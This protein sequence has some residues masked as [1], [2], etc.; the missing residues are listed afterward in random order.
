VTLRYRDGTIRVD[1]DTALDIDCLQRGPD[2]TVYAPGYRY[3]T[4]LSALRER[5]ILCEDRVLG[6]ETLAVD[7][8][9]E[10]RKYQRAALE[11]WEDDDRRGVLELPTGS[12]KTVIGLAAIECVGRPA[13][14][15]VPTVDEELARLPSL[16]RALPADVPVV[17]PRQ[18]VIELARD[19]YRTYLRLRDAGH[20]VPVGADVGH[21]RSVVDG[22][23]ATAAVVGQRR[24]QPGGPDHP[25]GDREPARGRLA[26][27]GRALAEGVGVEPI[28]R[29]VDGSTGLA[30][31][32]E[33]VLVALELDEQAAGVLDRGR[34]QPPHGT[35]LGDTFPGA[36]RVGVGVARPA[37][38]HPVGV[39]GS[40]AA[41]TAP[42]DEPDVQPSHREVAG[43]AE[44]G[45]P[46]A[47]HADVRPDPIGHTA[48]RV[49]SCISLSTPRGAR[50]TG[51]EGTLDTG[52]Q[53]PPDGTVRPRRPTVIRGDDPEPACS[54]T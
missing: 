16:E 14:V 44:P 21:G 19:K 30:F 13:L 8:P 36:G 46:A 5:D 6:D 34:R 47:D 31:G 35:V 33:V 3:A 20:A 40:S 37:V 10:L 15:V 29:D 24:H 32:L 54:V 50:R 38:E 17:A 41:E 51:D 39:A 28:D 12:G 2:G 27:F 43:D 53:D 26:E 22:D 1:T 23:P 52:G 25:V 7:S 45:R 18:E 9:Y 49:G 42:L 4:L 11:A 48:T